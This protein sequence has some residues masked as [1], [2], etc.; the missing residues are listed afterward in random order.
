MLKQPR[1][2][3]PPPRGAAR[4]APYGVQL[5]SGM[6]RLGMGGRRLGRDKAH[7]RGRCAHP[8]VMSHLACAD[9]PD[10]AEG[11]CQPTQAVHPI[12]TAGVTAPRSLSGN[13]RHPAG[14]RFST[15]IST[16]PGIGLYGGLPFKD[17]QPV[18]RLSLPVIQIRDVAEGRVRGLRRQL[19]RQAPDTDRNRFSRLRGRT[20]PSHEQH[21]A[22]A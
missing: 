16:R 17:A 9:E 19:H 10:R 3:R 12:M 6:N 15:S 22:T 2:G 18:V 5:D 13:G 20:H 8:L 21:R 4:G 11:E 1:T 7:A 14:A